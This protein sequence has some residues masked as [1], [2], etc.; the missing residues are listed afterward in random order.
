MTTHEKAP[1]EGGNSKIQNTGTENIIA[2]PDRV[3]S[4]EYTFVSHRFAQ[5]SRLTYDARGLGA[6]LLSY[7]GRATRE[8][9]RRSGP[10]SDSNM[11]QFIDEL[12]AFGFVS[13]DENGVLTMHDWDG[14]E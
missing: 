3:K 4:G 2:F 11:E 6:I 9:L 5:D 13:E 8:V 10:D 1:G 14:D 7:N 12:K